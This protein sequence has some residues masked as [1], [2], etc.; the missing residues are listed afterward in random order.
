MFMVIKGETKP[1]R[2]QFGNFVSTCSAY[3][4]VYSKNIRRTHGS[5]DPYG[6]ATHAVLLTSDRVPCIAL[7]FKNHHVVP[8]LAAFYT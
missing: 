7:S 1:K 6:V 5:D 2:K 8:S 4:N 3:V